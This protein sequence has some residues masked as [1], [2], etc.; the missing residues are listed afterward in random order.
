MY[1][2]LS[3]Q[4]VF[5]EKFRTFVFVKIINLVGLNCDEFKRLDHMQ[6]SYLLKPTKIPYFIKE[7]IVIIDIK[8]GKDILELNTNGDVY[9]WVVM[10]IANVVIK[11]T[12]KAI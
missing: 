9:S 10:N 11:A 2:W 6:G 7:K 4:Y 3:S 5:G 12:M 8:C 1:C